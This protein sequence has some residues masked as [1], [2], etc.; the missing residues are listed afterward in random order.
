MNQGLAG[1]QMFN[2]KAMAPTDPKVLALQQQS[3]DKSK[4]FMDMVSTESADRQA[5]MA[6][7]NYNKWAKPA[8]GQQFAGL[9]NTLAGQGMLGLK[10]N[11]GSVNGGQAGGGINPYYADFAEGVARADLKNYENSVRLGQDINTN[12]FNLGTGFLNNYQGSVK[13]TQNEQMNNQAM[14]ANYLQSAQSID[15][16]GMDAIAQGGKLGESASLAGA[17]AGGFLTSAANSA[18]GNLQQ[19]QQWEANQDNARNNQIWEA[20]WKNVL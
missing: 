15:K 13:A 10:V 4:G 18:A 3:L 2:Q 7:E 11:G 17:R 9:Q 8:Q 16:M 19:R 20:I 12:N 1:A 5:K 6:Y 14:G